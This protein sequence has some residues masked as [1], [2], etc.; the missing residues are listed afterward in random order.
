MFIAQTMERGG[1]VLAKTALEV[2]LIGLEGR[3]RRITPELA[4]ALEKLMPK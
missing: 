1:E 3:P 2:V 4:A